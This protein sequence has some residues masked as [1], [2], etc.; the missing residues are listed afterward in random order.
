MSKI[1]SGRVFPFAY[2]IDNCERIVYNMSSENSNK[3]SSMVNVKRFFNSKA[4]YPVALA[5]VFALCVCIWLVGKSAS[6][7]QNSAA[8]KA[9]ST[10]QVAATVTDVK[11]TR[12]EETS[13]QTTTEK[14]KPTTA[15]YDNNVAGQG[16]WSIP[17]K[18]AKID[19][20]YSN[21]TLVK[22]ETM[23]DYRI[24]D[25]IDFLA[26]KGTKVI[27]I[28]TGVVEDVY[29]DAFWGTVVK[30]NHGGGVTAKY[31]GLDK[32]TLKVK[33]GDKLKKDTQIG[34]VSVVPCENADKSHLHFET[35]VNGES[36]D[37]LYCMNKTDGKSE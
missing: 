21:G 28:N 6:R 26:Q 18:G 37:P 8:T 36:M 19:K 13:T 2:E 10:T 20:D 31:C 23:G 32:E 27:S 5:I 22:S 9:D 16:N 29:D 7:A 12:D 11:D 34:T 4:F 35:I 33:K 3:N 1:D 14:A 25:G 24:H 15:V 30:V 17:I